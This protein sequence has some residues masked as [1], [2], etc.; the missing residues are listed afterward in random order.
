[1]LIALALTAVAGFATIGGA[2]AAFIPAMRTPRS[3]GL[4]LAVAAG[5]MLGVS[6]LEIFPESVGELGWGRAGLWAAAG[7]LG[8]LAL[9]LL[10]HLFPAGGAHTELPCA[11]CDHRTAPH[12]HEH[13]PAR[14]RESRTA[15][16]RAG[17]VAAVALTLHNIPEGFATFATALH[18]AALAL[19]LVGA[20]AVHNIPEGLAVAVPV[21]ES[22]GSRRRAL[23]ITA[24]SGLS[25]PLGALAIFALVGPSGLESLWPAL[26]GIVAG[27]MVSMSV[28][29]L[30]PLAKNRLPW[31][32][33][34]IGTAA[35]A[36]IMWLSI[37]LLELAA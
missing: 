35:G 6:A 8:V 32:Q 15:M 34:A 19:P 14:G 16:I 1:M 25:E 13:T 28:L 24:L 12:A 10:A 9:N 18:S 21:L 27:I 7:T 11:H 17:I 30:L 5:A 33:L 22:T 29:E 3:V 2:L 20:I 37:E 36:G 31:P 26:A 23:V 4:A